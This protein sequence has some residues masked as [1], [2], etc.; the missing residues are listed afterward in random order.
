MKKNENHPPHYEKPHME[1]IK[2]LSF[3]PLLQ[4]SQGGQGNIPPTPNNNNDF[5]W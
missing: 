3:S 1:V 2:I 5:D 4:A